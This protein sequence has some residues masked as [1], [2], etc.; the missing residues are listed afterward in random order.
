MIAKKETKGPPLVFGVQLGLG[1]TQALI[2]TNK[3]KKEKRNTEGTNKGLSKNYVAKKEVKSTRFSSLTDT[4]F[5]VN[6][7]SESSV[8]GNDFSVFGRRK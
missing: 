7:L 8:G 5:P 1:Q 2:G 6:R 4:I 3:I